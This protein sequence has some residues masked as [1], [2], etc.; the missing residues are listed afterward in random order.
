[1]ILDLGFWKKLVYC[2]NGKMGLDLCYKL[3][4]RANF[5]ELVL[6]LEIEETPELKEKRFLLDLKIFLN[7]IEKSKSQPSLGI[8]ATDY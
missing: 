7:D 6:Q 8:S 3:F 5:E 4:E 1:M 2:M